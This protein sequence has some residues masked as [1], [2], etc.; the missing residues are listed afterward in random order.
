[1]PRQHQAAGGFQLFSRRAHIAGQGLPEPAQ[2]GLGRRR[3]QQ[4]ADLVHEVIAGRAVDPPARVGLFAGCQ[5]LLRHHIG[6]R[7]RAGGRPGGARLRQAL[8]EAPQV[9]AGRSQPVDV[10]DPETIQYA[11]RV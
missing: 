7:L 5:D 4:R 9:G 11:L 3:V 6:A 1:M 8:V 2:R 10:V